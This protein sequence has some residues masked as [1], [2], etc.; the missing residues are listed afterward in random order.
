MYTIQQIVKTKQYT[1]QSRATVVTMRK[2]Q[3]TTHLK[4]N[5]TTHTSH[6]SRPHTTVC[7]TTLQCTRT[8]NPRET[9]NTLHNL[10]T[11]RRRITVNTHVPTNQCKHH[12]PTC[13]T[14]NYDTYTAGINQLGTKDMH[15]KQRQ[16]THHPQRK[17]TNT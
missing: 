8:R 10:H 5:G 7:T 6:Q 13:S 3:R 9:C 17:Q 11:T 1:T 15:N 4:R 14:H 16:T 2:Q 12:N